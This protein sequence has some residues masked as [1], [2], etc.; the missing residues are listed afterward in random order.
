MIS[1]DMALSKSELRRTRV[2]R[3]I[4]RDIKERSKRK[5]NAPGGKSGGNEEYYV[6]KDRAMAVA[7][8]TEDLKGHI[9]KHR[10]N[11]M[12]THRHEGEIDAQGI[13]IIVEQISYELRLGDPERALA[14]ANKGLRHKPDHIRCQVLRCRCLILTNRS[15]YIYLITPALSALHST[16]FILYAERH[17]KR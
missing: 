16:T 2:F 4:E 17:W 1:D 6:D 13:E 8:G 14:Y 10:G 5:K 7:I 9:M 15:K 12:R 3:K 11:L